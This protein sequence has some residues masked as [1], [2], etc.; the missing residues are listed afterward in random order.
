MCIRNEPDQSLVGNLTPTRLHSGRDEPGLAPGTDQSC[1]SDQDFL[2]SVAVRPRRQL[3]AFTTD[4]D[5]LA[6]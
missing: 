5:P 6:Q 3:D 2:P 4:I 1:R